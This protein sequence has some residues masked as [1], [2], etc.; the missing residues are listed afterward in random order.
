MKNKIL[1]KFKILDAIDYPIL[2]SD[3]CTNK[4][5]YLNKKAS[6][7]FK[8]DIIG[9]FQNKI[10]EMLINNDSNNM[11]LIN[12]LKYQYWLIILIV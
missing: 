5:I 11:I 8:Y 6:S 3:I 7:E 9:E 10:V 1:H 12:F 2:I 4:I